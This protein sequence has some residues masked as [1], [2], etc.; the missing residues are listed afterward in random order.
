MKTIRRI[1]TV[2]WILIDDLIQEVLHLMEPDGTP[3]GMANQLSPGCHYAIAWYVREGL[4]CKY[5]VT[6][7]VRKL[8][9]V[10]ACKLFD[11]STR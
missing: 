9:D 4:L 11:I 7:L 1:S 10:S 2:A 3:N 6:G 8:S 5:L